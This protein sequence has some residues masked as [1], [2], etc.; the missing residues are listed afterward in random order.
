[1]RRPLCL[2]FLLA[3]TSVPALARPKIEQTVDRRSLDALQRRALEASPR[4]RYFL[5]TE[6]VHDVIEDSADEYAAGEIGKAT[7]L[8]KQAQVITRK[9]HILLSG[10]DKRLKKAQILLSNTAFRLDELLHASDYDNRPLIEQTLAQLTQAQNE[11][12]LQLF[13]K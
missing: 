13:Q 1:M 7:V 2:L 10:N 9:L 5:Y 4:D 6:L 11:A 8:L 3:A 12:M